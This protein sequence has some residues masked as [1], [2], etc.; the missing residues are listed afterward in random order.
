M[1]TLNED[2]VDLVEV[3]SKIN[4]LEE[5]SREYDSIRRLFE[6]MS[7]YF[8]SRYGVTM[9]EIMFEI[10]D[11]L[12]PDDEVKTIDNYLASHYENKDGKYDASLEEGVVVHPDDFD[13][14]E[15]RLVILPNPVRIAIQDPKTNHRE[16]VWKAA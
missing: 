5:T 7:E 2:L 13:F 12:C 3:K 6:K 1:H 16:I 9:E 10:Y 11:E 8:V 14:Q 15:G 4:S